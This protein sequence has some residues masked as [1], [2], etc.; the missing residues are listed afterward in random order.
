M[1][2]LPSP[3]DSKKVESDS[4]SDDGKFDTPAN[5]N[6]AGMSSKTSTIEGG[7][8]GCDDVDGGA[9]DSQETKKKKPRKRAPPPKGERVRYIL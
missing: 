8:N 4:D 3:T 1:T 2:L 7:G 9:N 6:P 5:S